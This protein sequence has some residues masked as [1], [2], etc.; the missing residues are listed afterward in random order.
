MNYT[1]HQLKVLL[2]VRETGSV[3]KAA[4]KLYLSQPAV[5][6]QLKKLQDQFEIP[7]FETVGRKISITEF[8]HEIANTAEIITEQIES[9]NYRSKIH[10]GE[11]AGKLKMAVV[12]T[13]K[14]IM[15]YFITDF[16][17]KHPGVD[18]SIDVTNK[19]S[20]IQNLENNEIDLAM[21]STIPAK[22]KVNS[23]RL[24]KNQLFLVVGN[25][26][27][28]NE[29]NIDKKQLEKQRLIYREHGS[30]TRNA[31]ENYISTRKISANKTIE[32]TSNEAVKQAVIAGLGVSIMPL[33]GIQ[34]SIIANE[35]KIIPATGLPLQTNWHIIWM[36]SKNLSVATKSFLDYTA[37]HK[38]EIINK[39]FKYV[40]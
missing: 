19:S 10:K 35:L 31:M 37:E 17:H 12:S 23:I 2:K 20:V 9:I 21:V 40:K 33:I 11:V 18:L 26:L 15:P 25:E 24:M 38:N 4:D 34:N 22:L 3:T 7:L 28:L 30:A 6:V 16:L 27:N 36:K 1:L 29:K 8:G 13:A 32:L 5:S 39:Y 14:Y